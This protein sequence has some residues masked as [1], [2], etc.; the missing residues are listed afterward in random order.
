MEVGTE[1]TRPQ[2]HV[3][4]GLCPEKT[5]GVRWRIARAGSAGLALELPERAETPPGGGRRRAPRGEPREGLFTL[6]HSPDTVFQAALSLAAYVSDPL[7]LELKT[8]FPF[9][10]FPTDLRF[11]RKGH[12]RATGCGKC[13]DNWTWRP[14]S[15][16]GGHRGPWWVGGRRHRRAWR[17]ITSRAN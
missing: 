12:F 13:W 2:I 15:L 5:G 3:R 9:A 4:N 16:L 11:T 10:S 14:L 7:S 8:T 1:A 6:G 17:R